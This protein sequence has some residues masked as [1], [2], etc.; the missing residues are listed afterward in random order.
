MSHRNVDGNRDSPATY[1]E[2]LT[3]SQ[4]TIVYQT[5]T[6]LTTATVTKT[7]S[8]EP[9]TVYVTQP[10]MAST[11]AADSEIVTRTQSR[12]MTVTET[13]AASPSSSPS[14]VLITVTATQTEPTTVYKSSPASTVTVTVTTGSP[15]TPTGTSTTSGGD[16]STA[17]MTAA[18]VAGGIAAL[19]SVGGIVTL[20]RHKRGQALKSMALPANVE[21][22][23]FTTVNPLYQAPPGMH[24]NPLY[25]DEEGML[26][27]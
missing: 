2:T 27:Y 26:D 25:Q 15:S 19:G 5:E 20:A 10:P 7:S 9:Q 8:A 21:H 23:E 11:I 4:P 22:K 14:T 16:G 18:S 12:V 24:V 17:S 6:Q 1:T 3:S 13:A